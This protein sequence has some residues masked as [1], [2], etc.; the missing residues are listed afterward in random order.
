MLQVEATDNDSG[1]NGK[2]RYTRISGDPVMQASLQL[3]QK[4]GEITITDN[5]YFDRETKDSKQL[6]VF[7]YS[8]QEIFATVYVMTVE[9]E[10]E[11]E[12]GERN[13]A[14]ARLVITIDDVNDVPPLFK[15]RK[16]EGFMT[17]DLTRLRNDLQVEAVDLD[18]M[19]TQNSDVRYEI[20]KGNYEKK[21]S[22]DEQTG[23]ISVAEPLQPLSTG[24]SARDLSVDEIDP[25]ITLHVRA[26]DLG[27]PSL[28][29]EVPVNIFTQ[30]VQSRF[31]LIPICFL[32]LTPGFVPR[33]VKFIV[34]GSVDS[35][36]DQEEQISD[37]LS[38][39]TGGEA[40]IQVIIIKLFNFS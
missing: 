28:D 29:S 16:Y 22:I 1:D 9:A 26:Y 38:T 37:L 27:I 36:S 35:V 10:D 7:C 6:T 32:L 18:K 20:I 4:T 15:R 21:F 30:D 2:V 33:V 12:P 11:G 17:P 14:T 24:R 34:D 31:V 39:I 8:K 25:I 23:V 13:A 5:R 3:D 40:E 19:G